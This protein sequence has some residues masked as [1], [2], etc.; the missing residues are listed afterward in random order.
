MPDILPSMENPRTLRGSMLHSNFIMGFLRRRR[1][2]RSSL[3]IFSEM[4]QVPLDR[5]TSN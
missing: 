3:L 2:T 5:K 4:I 1:G